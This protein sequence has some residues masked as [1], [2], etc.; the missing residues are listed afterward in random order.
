MSD[1]HTIYLYFHYVES[2]YLELISNHLFQGCFDYGNSFVK[3]D[4]TKLEMRKRLVFICK[5]AVKAR[6][7]RGNLKQVYGFLSNEK[8]QLSYLT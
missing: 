5:Y 7:S 6:P 1:C 4:I 3:R 8:E 2:I